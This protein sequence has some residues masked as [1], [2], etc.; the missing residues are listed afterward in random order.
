MPCNSD[1]MN[2]SPR[3]VKASRLACLLGELKGYAWSRHWWDGYHPEVYNRHPGPDPDEMAQEL[4]SQLRTLDVTKFS[5][6]LQIWWRDHQAA[7]AKRIEQEKREARELE[8]KELAE[9]ER[10]KKKYGD[11]EEDIM[12]I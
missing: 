4:C 3:E 7:D 6:E 5:L 2:A 11:T 8:A 1:H 9:Y 12:K 10:L